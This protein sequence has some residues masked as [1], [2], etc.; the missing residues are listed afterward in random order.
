MIDP[1]KITISTQTEPD[2]RVVV[3]AT[4]KLE[5]KRRLHPD[6]MTPVL[7]E[8]VMDNMKSCIWNQLYGDIFDLCCQNLQLCFKLNP[9][10]PEQEHIV[11]LAAELARK[12]CCPSRS[13]WQKCDFDQHFIDQPFDQNPEADTTTD[14]SRRAG[15]GKWSFNVPHF[16]NRLREPTANAGE[17]QEP[18]L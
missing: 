2:G 18:T 12:L 15:F 13:Q 9:N 11:A 7:V 4:L 14:E 8:R 16:E 6:E 10:N 5:D 1:D 3:T 17:A